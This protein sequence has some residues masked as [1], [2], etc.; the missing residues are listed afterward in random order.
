MYLAF[1]SAL[2][3]LLAP[4][5]WAFSRLQRHHS[6]HSHTVLVGGREPYWP[7]EDDM[8]EW[9]AYLDMPHVVQ[10]NRWFLDRCFTLSSKK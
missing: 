9:S 8:T 5:A 10:Q 4:S 6:R 7:N 1:L 2:R 3:F